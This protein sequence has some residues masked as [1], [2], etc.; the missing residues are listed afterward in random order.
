MVSSENMNYE[1]ISDLKEIESILRN[2]GY[3]LDACEYDDEDEYQ[4]ALDRLYPDE[5]KSVAK[6]ASELGSIHGMHL[7]GRML[8]DEV[9]DLKSEGNPYKELQSKARELVINA[10]KGGCLG[11]MD[12]LATEHTEDLGPSMYEQ[13]AFLKLS[14]RDPLEHVAYCRDRLNMTI[15]QEEIDK[16]LSLFEELNRYMIDNDI[17]KS[18]CDCIF[19]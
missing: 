7:Y 18:C 3:E 1:E 6:R 10:A 5:V 11:A 4:E 17:K 14:G 2:M 8:G 15:T 13:L 12:D 16:G 9:R 19:P